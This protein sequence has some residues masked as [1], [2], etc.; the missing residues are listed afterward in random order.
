M[1]GPLEGAIKNLTKEMANTNEECKELER[2]WLR[3]QTELVTTSAE[4]D[5]LGEKNG[6]QQARVT[7]ITQQQLRLL[8]DLREIKGNL[9]ESRRVNMELQKDVSKLNALIS[10]NHDDEEKLQGANYIVE[11]DCIEGLK[12]AEKE[13]VGVQASIVSVKAEKAELLDEIIEQERQ[14]LLWEKKI[15]LDKETRAALDPTVGVEESQ[16][17]EKEIHRMELRFEALK[18]EQER[19]SIEME[20]AITKRANIANRYGKS[21]SGPVEVKKTVSAKDLT[22]ASAKKK[23]GA[24]KKDARSLAE[25]TSQYSSMF[26]NKKRQLNGI[27]DELESVTSEYG[28]TE[29]YCHQLQNEINELL[30]QKQLFQERLQYRQKFLGRMRDYA[31][32]GGMGLDPSQS[33]QVER[34]VLASS[35][36]L[37]NVREII[38]DLQDSFPHIKE[39]LQRVE[40]MTDP[41]IEM[42]DGGP[43]E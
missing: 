12:D 29:E 9:K 35:Q 13:C 18:R 27:L 11:M 3:R 1:L 42:D 19:L 24:L 38:L 15:Q 43:V 41:S 14:A 36:A 30:Y 16:N 34:R 7:V 25:E 17:M 33:L 28:D 21:S 31:S 6:E 2:S 22:Q 5:A 40:A 8:K 23:I 26:E 37:D 10:N 32:Q 39:V 20:R 4:C